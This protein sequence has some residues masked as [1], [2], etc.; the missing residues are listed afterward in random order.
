[1]IK[2]L[3][4]LA[5]EK[6][7]FGLAGLGLLALVAGCS[8]QRFSPSAKLSKEIDPK[9]AKIVRY[10]IEN[11]KPYAGSTGNPDG[12]EY[13][14]EITLGDGRTVFLNYADRTRKRSGLTFSSNY[15]I[16]SADSLEARFCAPIGWIDEDE[17]SNG[18]FDDNLD[19]DNCMNFIDYG[20][21][22]DPEPDRY[23]S[24]LGYSYEKWKKYKSLLDEIVGAIK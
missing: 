24:R 13:W 6:F 4:R 1:M 21:D 20:L 11:G 8:A 7:S 18:F 5:K 17:I 15:Q 22:G 23:S 12:I 10:L 14:K 2:D 9:T 3:C 19:K 16:D